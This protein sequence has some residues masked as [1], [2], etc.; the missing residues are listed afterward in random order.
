MS[1]EQEPTTKK[2]LDNLQQESWQLEL[3]VSGFVIFLLLGVSEPLEKLT[4]HT[5]HLALGAFEFEL[6]IIPLTV[7][8]GAWIIMLVNLLLHVF[9]RGLWISTIG[10][11]Y[12]SGDID[13]DSLSFQSKF[14]HFLHKR[15]ASFDHYIMS[16]E[17][18]CSV[19]FSFTFLLIFMVFSLGL[20]V[21]ILVVLMI[22][23]QRLLGLNSEGFMPINQ[24]LNLFFSISGL[25]YAIDFISLG[26]LKRKKWIAFWYYPI[27]RIMSFM[28]ASKL[29]RPLYYNLIDNKFGRKMGYFLVPYILLLMVLS[30]LNIV[31]DTY[32]PRSFKEDQI[33]MAH[34]D[35]EENYQRYT[36]APSIPDKYVAHDFLEVFIPYAPQKDDSALEEHCGSITPAQETGLRLWGV[37]KSS[38][39]EIKEATATNAITVRMA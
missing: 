21:S 12:V 9:L 33:V 20:F 2:W 26:W 11:R 39:I 27:Y 1:D 28:T 25:L 23:L 22:S 18:L 17:K 4:Y 19:I 10:L 8:K 32:Y 16:L 30:S 36:A 29:Y 5:S 14:N 37:I 3:I 31:T 13:L 15:I 34:Y 38:M 7:L 35:S 6:F 24:A